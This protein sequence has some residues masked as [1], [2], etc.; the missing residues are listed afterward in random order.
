M[1]ASIWRG[2]G[3]AASVP[4][5]DWLLAEGGVLRSA[6]AAN[7]LGHGVAELAAGDRFGAFELRREI[8]RGGQAAVFLADRVDGAYR[9]QV[10]IKIALGRGGSR[11]FARE[12][13]LLAEL[14]HPHL[15]RLID[16]GDQGGRL[17][18]AMDHVDGPPIDRYCSL[19]RLERRARI[20]L[21]LQVC[22]AVSFAHQRLLVHRDI[23][24]S[25]VLVDSDGSPKLLDFGIAA[26]LTADASAQ[27]GRA[28]TP[29]YASPEQ[30]AGDVVGPG[31]DQYQLALLLQRMLH[32]AAAEPGQPPTRTLA[33]QVAAEPT[34][35]VAAPVAQDLGTELQA[36]LA[37]AS[38]AEVADR[39]G[40]VVEFADD[41][42]R[43]LQH[44]PVR[45]LRAT[46]RYVTRKLLRRHPWRVLTAVAAT[47][48]LIALV[49][50]FT[51]RLAEQRDISLAEAARA[52]AIKN[53][54]IGMFRDGDPTR[55]SDP[56][57]SARALIQSGVVRVES[58]Q[59][60]PTDARRELLHLLV[61]IQ[62][63][64]G[65]G[66]HAGALL[67]RIDP[68]QIDPA[69][70]AEMQGRLADIR[71]QPDAAVLHYQQAIA[72]ADSPERQLR[73]VRAENDAGRTAASAERLARLLKREAELPDA[74]AASAW[75]ARGVLHWRDG[76]PEQALRDYD[77]ALA[78]ADRSEVSISP[79][80]ALINRGLALNDL[81]RFD[82]ALADYERAEAGLARYPNFRH[83][84]LI[85]QNR[86]MSLLRNG[87]VETARDVWL[88]LLDLVDGG[89]NPGI[90]AST[91]HNLASAADRLGDPVGAIEYSLRAERLR[92][93]LGD[94]PSAL[95]S[96]INV[97]V[98]L[99][100]VDLAEE[101]IR[102]AEAAV[103]A[104][105]AIDRPDLAVRARLAAVNNRCA[106]AHP[107]C[108]AELEASAAEF[109][110]TG[111]RVKLLDTLESIVQLGLERGD[112]L[113][114]TRAA[115]AMA[116]EIGELQDAELQDRLA[117]VRAFASRD[118]DALRQRAGRS[119]EARR[120]LVLLALER[121]DI[122]EARAQ[123]T[124]L[125]EQDSVRYWA[126]REQVADAA[127]DH[128]DL[129]H[130]R[131]QRA[132]LRTRVQ[133][134]LAQT[135]H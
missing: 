52:E 111:N 75:I 94:L 108:I 117:A 63:R 37:R 13:Q 109:A 40:S 65:D 80:A 72:H 14:K 81:G 51:L 68:A 3:T 131:A 85:L 60:L 124:E 76:K 132:A 88:K 70:L 130:A 34:A 77:R 90:E 58:D 104:A 126:L 129:V 125:A 31:S 83:Q 56:D 27:A 69:I 8:G 39:Y 79:V 95:S 9:Q 127:R 86:G 82:E 105:T 74:L 128:A 57:L 33:T 28:Y 5:P 134:L 1:H 102:M 30:L 43:Y 101:G 121:W 100:T 26:L 2:S 73:L 53:F 49:T 44:R 20:E 123:L 41:L 71:G 84:G 17:W 113:A 42:Q 4:L 62:L 87:Q 45:A 36:I 21:F 32:A 46:P 11:D 55:G 25:N 118:L 22:I 116:A 92:R 64:L 16:G 98:K 107:D 24:P 54:L 122:R 93:Q 78:R 6:L 66:E 97:A 114:Q 106:L 96:M 67:E 10:A 47:L 99:H 35:L 48:A 18:F 112:Q 135:P 19:H 50:G 7:L 38:A 12:R 119:S 103:V 29:A 115:E 89:V 91:V 59:T 120:A 61:D 15:A 133:S 110:A 23:K